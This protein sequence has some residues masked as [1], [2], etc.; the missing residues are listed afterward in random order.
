[1]FR[2]LV[3]K[4]CVEA[5]LPEVVQLVSPRQLGVG[6]DGGVEAVLHSFN[7]LIQCPT[8]PQSTVLTLIDFS[9]AF[10]EVN[11]SKLLDIV[12]AKFPSIY[13]WVR[14]CYA[15]SAPLFFD[16][17]IVRAS[18][19]IQQGDPLSSI[20]FAVLLDPILRHIQSEFHLHIGAIL[21]D[22]TF[23]GTIP[24]T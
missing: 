8:L 14:Y 2:R 4:L 12:A 17:A 13:P 7:R 10:N 22:V 1:M 24:N 19:G 18:R 21:D 11:R 16:D 6:I 20:L 23:A 9:N 5:I 3:S 15:V